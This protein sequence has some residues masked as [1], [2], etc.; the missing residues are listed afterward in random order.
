LL[1]SPAEASRFGA[2]ARAT[3]AE[4]FTADRMVETTL[5]KYRQILRESPR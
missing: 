2:A 3:I 5:E 4:R 1:C